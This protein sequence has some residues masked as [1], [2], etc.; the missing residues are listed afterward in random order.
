MIHQ[1]NQLNCDILKT[2]LIFWSV[3]KSELS[4]VVMS[5]VAV[6][7]LWMEVF[8]VML[9]LS[10]GTSRMEFVGYMKVPQPDLYVKC[11]F[12]STSG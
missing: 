4:V 6:S 10:E 12:E 9:H 3:N 11:V 5:P 7:E 1:D 2:S 8:R